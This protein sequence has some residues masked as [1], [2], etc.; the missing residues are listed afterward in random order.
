MSVIFR[1]SAAVRVRLPSLDDVEVTAAE[2]TAEHLAV[3]E[4]F[5]C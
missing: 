2:E 1:R 3:D 5:R 4:F